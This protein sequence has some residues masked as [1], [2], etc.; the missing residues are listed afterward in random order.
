MPATIFVGQVLTPQY[1]LGLVALSYLVSFAGSL[2]AIMC[3]NRLL[4]T[5]GLARFSML[6][7]AAVALGGIGIWSMHF[8]GMLAYE[9]PV[10]IVYEPMLTVGSLAAAVLISGIALYLAG[11]R[12]K[13][14]KPGW[15]AA[16]ILAG[17]GI[18]VM[19]YMGM[20]AMQL[21]AAMEM[22]LRVVAMSMGI[23]VTAAAVALWL[24]FHTSS[25]ARQTV[26]AA[27]MAL[28]VCAMHYVGMHAAT[29]VCTAP[30]AARGLTLSE[31][32]LVL[33]VFSIIGMVLVSIYWLV[34]DVDIAAIRQRVVVARRG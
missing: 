15:V 9:L 23:A 11:G 6:A 24:A 1:S 5:N 25:L 29:M 8:I 27:V 14:S 20:Y 28:A 13:F 10:P 34:T 16:S 22:D 2:T 26:S 19:H 17:L 3:A 7:C 4:K 31:T 32:D 12:C 33:V 30:I 18:C 21:R